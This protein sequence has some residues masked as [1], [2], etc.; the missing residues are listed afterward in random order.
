MLSLLRL[1]LSQL[2]SLQLSLLQLTLSQLPSLVLSLLPS[3]RLMPSQ[4][5]V[6]VDRV[7]VTTRLLPH[8][9]CHVPA[10]HVRARRAQ[11]ATVTL[12]VAKLA[13]AQVAHVRVTTRSQTSRAQVVQVVAPSEESVQRTTRH[14][15]RKVRRPKLAVVVHV[16]AVHAQVAHVQA[17]VHVQTQ[18]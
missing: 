2:P 11:V 9:A 5:S 14:V 6:P 8:K 18:V 4:H 3:H 1:T 13:H 10:H 16:R 15:T 12:P 17:V 7:Q